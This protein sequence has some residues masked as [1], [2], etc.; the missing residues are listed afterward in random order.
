MM[1]NQT[2]TF[3]AEIIR[4][5]TV[6]VRCGNCGSEQVMNKVYEPY[7]KQL[8]NCKECRTK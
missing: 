4:S 7:V 1:D 8:T 3:F 2:E 6:V 5:E